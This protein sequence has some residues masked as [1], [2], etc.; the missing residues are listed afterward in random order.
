VEYPAFTLNI[1]LLFGLGLVS[2]R[3]ARRSWGAAVL[4]GA[5]DALLGLIVVVA[6][7]LIK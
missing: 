7:A 3:R 2:A 4:T 1:G 6:N 5:G